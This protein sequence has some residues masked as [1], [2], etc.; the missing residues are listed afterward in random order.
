MTNMTAHT[1]PASRGNGP[2]RPATDTVPGP[3]ARHATRAARIG[4]LS[5]SLGTA[6]LGGAWQA[7]ATSFPAALHVSDALFTLSGLLW[8]VL[9]AQ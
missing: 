5:I 6:G 8:L 1:M 3:T 7:A 4:L 2:A 9:L